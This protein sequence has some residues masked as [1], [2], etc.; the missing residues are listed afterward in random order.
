MVSGRSLKLGLAVSVVALVSLLGVPVAGASTAAT[1]SGG[2]LIDNPKIWPEYAVYGVAGG[3]LNV[4][5]DATSHSQRLLALPAGARF[6]VMCQLLGQSVPSPWGGS[7]AVWDLVNVS[8]SDHLTVPAW[9]SDV[10]VTTPAVN[11]ISTSVF[12]VPTSS[13]VLC[14]P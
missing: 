2:V 13:A 6:S 12:F 4:R 10:Y 9:V 5:A 14:A 8:Y 11:D 1:P 3:R 7:S